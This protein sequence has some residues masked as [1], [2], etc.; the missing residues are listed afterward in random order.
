MAKL[1]QIDNN[2]PVLAAF[3]VYPTTNPE[4]D[5]DHYSVISGYDE[6]GLYILST[7]KN[8]SQQ[9]RTWEQLLSKGMNGLSFVSS[10]SWTKY[11]FLAFD[12][13]E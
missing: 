2:K 9:Y 5:L 1:K 6:K 4:W 7:W 3:K 12:I 13:Y 11:L 8:D 10:L